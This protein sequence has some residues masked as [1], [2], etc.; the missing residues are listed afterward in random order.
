MLINNATL[1]YF[2]SNGL[3][4]T[5]LGLYYNDNGILTRKEITVKGAY[6]LGVGFTYDISI[7]KNKK[8]EFAHLKCCI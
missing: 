6:H 4:T 8:L 5:I 7:S 2:I 1:E 3:E